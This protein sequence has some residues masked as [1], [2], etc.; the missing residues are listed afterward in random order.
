LGV[1]RQLCFENLPGSGGLDPYEAVC[2][3]SPGKACEQILGQS[4]AIQ[5]RDRSDPGET[6]RIRREPIE[7]P[8]VLIDLDELRKHVHSGDNPFIAVVISGFPL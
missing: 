7:A 2:R 6:A 3:H 5:M 8:D 4:S 1:E